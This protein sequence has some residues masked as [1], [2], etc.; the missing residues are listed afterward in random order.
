MAKIY[1]VVA[2]A[3]CY[4]LLFLSSHQNDGQIAAYTSESMPSSQQQRALSNK[5]IYHA[6]R[7]LS[8]PF[9]NGSC[10]GSVVTLPRDL[11]ST[12]NLPFPSFGNLVLP[13][14]DVKVWLPKEYHLPEFRYHKFPVLQ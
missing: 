10:G 9:P 6:D 14:R 1:N 5:S 7:P 13:P 8:P 3:A 4:L 11:W 2:V 12:D